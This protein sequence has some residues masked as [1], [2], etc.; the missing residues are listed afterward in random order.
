MSVGLR[1]FHVSNASMFSHETPKAT[2]VSVPRPHREAQI[3]KAC[4]VTTTSP[5]EDG[6]KKRQ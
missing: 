5:A 2:G 6:K 1:E 4:G 3:E